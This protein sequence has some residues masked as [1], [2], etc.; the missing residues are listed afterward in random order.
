MML[1]GSERADE[2]KKKTSEGNRQ[3][4]TDPVDA[5]LQTCFQ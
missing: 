3:R 5:N 1:K 4:E 2:Y